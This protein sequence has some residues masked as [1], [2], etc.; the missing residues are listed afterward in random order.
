M[1]MLSIPVSVSAHLALAL[2]D[3]R[4]QVRPVWVRNWWRERFMNHPIAQRGLSLF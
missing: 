1:P 2:S 4:T 3:T